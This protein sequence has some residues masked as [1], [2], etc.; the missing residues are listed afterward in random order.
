MIKIAVIIVVVVLAA[1]GGFFFMLMKGPDLAKYE[2]LREPRITVLPDITVLA[3]SFETSGD[4]LKEVFGFLFKTYFK[5]K[6]VPKRP[7][8]MPPPVA[9][10]ENALDFEMESDKRKAILEKIIWKGVAALPLATDIVD[11]PDVQNKTLTARIAHWHYGETAEILHIGP[12][13]QEP[14][15][16]RRLMEY[17]K[18]QGYEISGLHEEVYLRGP[19][20]P[21]SKP[22]KYYT[23]I[24]YPVKKR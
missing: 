21:L 4:G 7:G 5:I 10:Y 12:Y 19:G 8:K 2:H 24:R 1:A 17:I 18:E 22:E 14:P 16:V 15:T 20:T 3:A 13:D 23:L 11:L 9:R 6:G